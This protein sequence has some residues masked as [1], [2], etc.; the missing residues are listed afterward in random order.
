GGRLDAS[1]FRS[2]SI[3]GET[4]I[5]DPLIASRMDPIADAAHDLFDEQYPQSAFFAYLD[6]LIQVRVL[7]ALKIK[8]ASMVR[9]LDPQITGPDTHF[10]ED[11]APLPP[12]ISMETYVRTDFIH[13]QFHDISVARKIIRGVADLLNE[14][15]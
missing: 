2:R 11:P 14:S 9:Y 13:R 12:L 8:R 3:F 7:N 15:L 1:P 5:Q 4:V 6:I 10:Q